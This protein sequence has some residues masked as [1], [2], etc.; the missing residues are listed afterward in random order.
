MK[1]K[2]YLTNKFICLGILISFSILPANSPLL[3]GPYLGQQP[4]DVVPQPFL[5]EVFCNEYTLHGPPIF[6]PDGKEVYWTPMRGYISKIQFMQNSKDVWS[7]P[8][9]P[10]F[11]PTFLGSGDPFF[12]PDG[13]RLFFTKDAIFINGPKEIIMFVDKKGKQWTKAKSV[14]KN[15][16]ALNL[17]W[18]ISVNRNLDLYFQ[19]RNNDLSDGSIYL[20]KYV[21]DTYQTPEKLGEMINTESWENFPF[22][23]PD[24]SYLIFS[25]TTPENG[26]DLFITFKNEHGTWSKPKNM[27]Q[28]NSPYHDMYPIV[29][30]DGKYLFFLSDR[31]G[32]S[33]PFWV[34][35]KVIEN[36]K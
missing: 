9:S 36:L 13:S 6:S 23:A 21:N 3:K 28:I 12:S 20:S 2:V 26:D 16:N 1:K 24:D 10:S 35:S 30:P 32:G 22:I 33:C 18:Q 4:P 27:D 29:T 11:V 14:S 8:G 34:S 19:V 5:H 25:R 17:H 31:D 7:T 15:V